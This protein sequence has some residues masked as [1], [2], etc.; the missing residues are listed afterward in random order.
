MINTLG[1]YRVLRREM[2]ENNSSASSP[3]TLGAFK[4]DYQDIFR[5]S[6]TKFQNSLNFINFLRLFYK[7]IFILDENY[8]SR[9]L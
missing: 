7:I 4:C 3:H 2:V 1:A 6:C 9:L 8:Y 5:I